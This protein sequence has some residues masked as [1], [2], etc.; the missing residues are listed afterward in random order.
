MARPAA[1]PEISLR[2]ARPDDYAFAL[3]LYLNST[4]RLLVAL[5]RWDE[6]RVLSRFAQ[7]WQLDQVQ[8]IRAE[9]GDI[10]WLQV[11]ESEETLHVD[12]LHLVAAYRGLGIGTR[13]FRELM[14]RAADTGRTVG[15]NVIRGNTAIALY[16]RLGFQVTGEDEEKIQMRWEPSGHTGA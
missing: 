16:Q 11:S 8:V 6:D 3:D 9:G 10:G 14:G 1:A 12:Q 4:K 2:A 15:L 7:G 13:L 5:G